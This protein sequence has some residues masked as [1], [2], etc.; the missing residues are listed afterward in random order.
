[1]HKRHCCVRNAVVTVCRPPIVPTITSTFL[2]V[3]LLLLPPFF[4]SAFK[5]IDKNTVYR[6]QV[7]P[8]LTPKESI[9]YKAIVGCIQE[10]Y[11]S[12]AQE[13]FE[14]YDNNN[15]GVAN[16]GE[17]LKLFEDCELDSYFRRKRWV[18][19]II[20]KLDQNQDGDLTIYELHQITLNIAPL[21]F[22]LTEA[23][24]D[25]ECVARTGPRNKRI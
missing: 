20:N 15:N 25:K 6:P 23:C 1:M 3:I 9:A 11:N 10:K 7:S 16:T 17:I 8:G 18:Q 19:R 4:S 22:K 12:D 21:T 24:Y 5:N 2:I 14:K 13:A